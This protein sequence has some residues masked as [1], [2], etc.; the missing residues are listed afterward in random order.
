MELI[1]WPNFKYWRRY[2]Q[3]S[4]ALSRCISTEFAVMIGQLHMGLSQDRSYRS[5]S[6]GIISRSKFGCFKPNGRDQDPKT[7]FEFQQLYYY[8]NG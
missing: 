2:G 6:Y 3:K 1:S 4:D 8:S 5:T 7:Q